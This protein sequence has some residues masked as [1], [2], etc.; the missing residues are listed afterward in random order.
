[1]QDV[2]RLAHVSTATVSLIL[3][4]R[5]NG[6]ARISPGTRQRVLAAV[7]KLRYVPNQNARNLRR[8]RTDRVCLMVSRLGVPYYE[9]LSN[10][11]QAAAEERGYSLVI[12]VGGSPERE[13]HVHEQLQRGLA[14][15]VVMVNPYSLQNEDLSRLARAGLAVVV[16]SNHLAGRDFDSVR[17]TESEA[18]HRAVTYLIEQG[19]RRIAF[20]GSFSERLSHRLRCESYRR[21][22]AEHQIPA[23]AA[24]IQDDA[25][26]S[27]EQAYGKTRVL[28]GLPER[29]TA[30]LAASDVAAV[31][32]IWA[33]RDAGLRVPEDVAVIGVGNIP[34][35]GITQP[36]LTTVGP[37][38]TDWGHVTALLFSR[39]EG[40]APADG[41]VHLTPC[42]FILRGSA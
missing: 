12:A 14:D 7:A 24:L 34:E 13:R 3:S 40:S 22:L 4:G 2:A 6:E 21:A 33:V 41:R 29:P 37:T 27:R 5:R 23:A 1:M 11:V 28:L 32:A 42:T 26:S 20:L 15:G 38:A 35:G 16:L 9:L 31:S 25:G 36:P 8:Q 17:T 18:C 39:L 10:A 30:V 19:H